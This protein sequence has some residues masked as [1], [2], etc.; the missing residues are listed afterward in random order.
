MEGKNTLAAGAEIFIDSIVLSAGIDGA[1]SETIDHRADWKKQHEIWSH[2]NGTLA[3]P[4]PSQQDLAAAV[5]QLQGAVELRD[6]LLDNLYN[7]TKIP[8]KTAKAPY[9]IMADLGIIRPTLKIQLR[10][11][12]NRLAY[13][14]EEPPLRREECEWLSDTAWY[15]LKATDRLAQQ[16]VHVLGIEY[17]T[18]KENHSFFSVTFNRNAWSAW[19]EGNVAPGFLLDKASADCLSVRL[20]RSEIQGYNNCHLKFCGEVTG[21]RPAVDRLIRCFFDESAL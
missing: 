11:L 8:N 6:R 21:S 12:R 3:S 14:I 19:I 2:A 7:F 15:Y 20:S 4:S 13:E 17:G 18:D 16:C 1:E 9:P 10:E 5:I